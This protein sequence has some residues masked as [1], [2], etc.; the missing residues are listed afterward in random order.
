VAEAALEA[1]C[2]V[3]RGKVEQELS[4]GDEQDGVAGEHRLVRD[5]AGDHG[6]AQALR[7]D[8]NDVARAV[9]EF[10]AERGLDGVAVDV[11]RPVPFVVGH[12]F[13]AADAAASKAPFEAALRA[14]LRLALG[15]ELED[16]DGAAALLG[17]GSHEVVEVGGG[18]A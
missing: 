4:G 5:V 2:R 10:E 14:V 7:C 3:L 16:L 11:L 12:R 8:E 13:E 15:E 17:R 6:L 1:A 18:V 9:E